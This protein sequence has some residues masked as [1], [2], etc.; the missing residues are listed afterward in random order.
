[1]NFKYW[2]EI[3]QAN[4]GYKEGLITK[5]EWKLLIELTIIA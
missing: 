2:N 5:E 4:F 1:M 3:Q